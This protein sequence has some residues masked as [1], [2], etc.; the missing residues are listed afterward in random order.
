[1]YNFCGNLDVFCDENEKR[2]LLL[3]LI[4]IYSVPIAKMPN[5]PLDLITSKAFQAVDYLVKEDGKDKK[6]SKL[7]EF[8]ENNMIEEDDEDDDSWHE[9]DAQD[10]EDFDY[11]DPLETLEPVLELKKCWMAIQEKRPAD[12]QA[13]TSCIPENEMNVIFGGFGHFEKT[14]IIPKFA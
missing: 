2:I 5:I 12:F 13:I 14:E 11:N 8:V 9:D 4:G 1:M 10:E 3:G 7:D 6:S